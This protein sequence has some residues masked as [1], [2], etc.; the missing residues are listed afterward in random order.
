MS[1]LESSIKTGNNLNLLRLAAAFLVL[2]GHCW[3]IAGIVGDPLHKA[4]GYSTGDVGLAIFFT[5]SGLLIS[6]SMSS[7]SAGSYLAKR[8]LRI[9]PAL[10]VVTLF[11]VLVVGPLFYAGTPAEYFGKFP[12]GHLRNAQIFG[13]TF[14]IPGVFEGNALH[15][16]NGSTWTLA[17]EAAF[18]LMLP[19]LGL[20]GVMRAG[21]SILLAA[22]FVAGYA[23]CRYH[24]YSFANPGPV[25]VQG[26]AL[27]P[28][29]KWGS[30]FFIGAAF[31]SNRSRLRLDGGI[32]TCCLVLLIACRKTAG[33]EWALVAL[34]GYLTLYVGL[35][36]PKIFEAYEKIG[37]LS[38]GVYIYA[39]PIQQW[40]V[41]VTQNSVGPW[42]LAAATTPVIVL[43]SFA[44]WHLVEKPALALRRSPHP[45]P[46]VPRVI[47]QS[48]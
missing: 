4:I 20:V 15:G 26:V 14:Y 43:V 2:F 32:A 3:P 46:S 5:L 45:Q 9:L 6:K 18:Y 35:G 39:W 8:A 12:W 31:W 47:A 34:G 1:Q 28:I 17:V 16:L 25:F 24:G 38:Y 27:H 13:M 29:L 42:Q 48:A 37:D 21:P 44:S 23:A 30:Y 7:S 11:E 41:A 33:A 19:I 36:L 22:G 40:I 10:I